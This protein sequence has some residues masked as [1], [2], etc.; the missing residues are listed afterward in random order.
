MRLDQL[1]FFIAA[2]ESGS[3]SG[4][5]RRVHLAQPAFSAHIKALEQDLGVTLFLRSTRGVSLTAAGKRLYNGATALFRHVEQVRQETLST[6]NEPSGDVR[7]VLAGSLAP[8]LAGRVFF[9]VQRAYPEIRLSILDLLRVSGE[10]LVTARLV[11]FG[12]LPNAATLAGAASEAVLSQELYLVGRT[13]PGA[14]IPFRELHRYPLVMGGR[15]NQLRIDLENTAAQ[16]G[17]RINVVSEQDSL[18]IYRSIIMQGEFYTVVPY[19]A[20]VTDI[21]SGRLTAARI[22]EPTVERTVSLV[23]HAHSDLSVAA[24]AVM[25]RLRANLAET[26]RSNSLRGRL[27]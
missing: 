25:D 17:Y 12:L 13:L 2:A 4:A 27:L 20:Y 6:G 22:V 23:W 5:A 14:E 3:I 18:S 24:R 15:H 8:L 7:I 10:N 26:I 1:T 16:G 11:D 21:E 9:D 19:S